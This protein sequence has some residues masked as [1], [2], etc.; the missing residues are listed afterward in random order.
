MSETSSVIY[1]FICGLVKAINTV[2][3]SV[4]VPVPVPVPVPFPVPFAMPVPVS[5]P[6]RVA[7]PARVVVAAVVV[8]VVVAAVL[9]VA[10][11]ILVVDFIY[12]RVPPAQKA[13]CLTLACFRS[14]CAVSRIAAV[15]SVCPS[16][17]SLRL[18][19]CLPALAASS[20]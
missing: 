15:C 13:A 6:V 9:T 8:D 7:V 12:S 11:V 19:V 16:A 10:A 17:P 20:R 3:Q 1:C 5:V 2:S 14:A 4:L 18:S